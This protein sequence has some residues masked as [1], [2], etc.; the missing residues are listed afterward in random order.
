MYKRKIFFAT[1][2]AILTVVIGSFL[3]SNVDA[4]H[5]CPSVVYIT[6]DAI[7]DTQS[8]LGIIVCL[9]PGECN[10]EGEYYRFYFTIRNYNRRR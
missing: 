1:S 7:S 8:R 3:V 5:P 4:T 10:G 2:A 6:C 9:D